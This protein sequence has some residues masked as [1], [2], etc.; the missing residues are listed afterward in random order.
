M[1]TASTNVS[2]AA[3]VHAPPAIVLSLSFRIHR[4]GPARRCTVPKARI[5]SDQLL[6]PLLPLLL[7]PP[8]LL[9]PLLAAVPPILCALPLFVRSHVDDDRYG[10]SGQ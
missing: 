6:P 3:S 8:L 5:S 10:A 1:I 4:I 2:C 9:P 7:L